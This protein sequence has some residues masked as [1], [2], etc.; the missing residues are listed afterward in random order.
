MSFRLPKELQ[1]WVNLLLGIWICVSPWSLQ[2]I[3][4]VAAAENA[5]GIGF[6]V[7]TAEVFTF[8][9]LRPLE[10]WINIGLG[11]WLVISPWVLNV[12]KASAKINFVAS[13]LALGLLAAYELRDSRRKPIR[14]A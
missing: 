10:E 5:V 13:G 14:R 3:D 6:L 2:F 8:S 11:A 9:R 12:T 7:I 4:D 1:D